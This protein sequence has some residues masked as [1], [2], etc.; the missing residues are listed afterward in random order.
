MNENEGEII[1]W[2]GPLL[3]LN[4][5]LN[6]WES[7]L[8]SDVAFAF[9]FVRCKLTLRSRSHWALSDGDGKMGGKWQIS[10]KDF[11]KE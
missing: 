7:H 1:F 2:S 11:A 8:K 4:N 3:N 6:L 10:A 5:T 9:D